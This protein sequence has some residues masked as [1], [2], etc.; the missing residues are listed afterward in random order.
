MR[1]RADLY[2]AAHS[3]IQLIHICIY[4]YIGSPRF[5]IK[6]LWTF[7]TEYRGSVVAFMFQQFGPEVCGLAVLEAGF[8]V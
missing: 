1:A 4:I 2:I 3:G 6:A 5:R 8:E 7:D